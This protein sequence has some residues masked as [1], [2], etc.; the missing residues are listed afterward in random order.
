MKPPSV[1]KVKIWIDMDNSPHVPFFIPIIKELERRGH[2]VVLTTRDE[3]Q[4]CRLADFHKLSYRKIGKHYGANKLLKLLGTLWRSLQLAPMILKERPDLSLSHGSRALIVLSSVLRIPTIQAFDYE[5]AQQ[6]P[7]IVPALGVAPRA[8]D[9][10]SLAKR[11][12][13]GLRTYDGLKED[14]YVSSFKPDPSILKVLG[15][16]TDDIVA[17]IRPPATQAHY[18]NP[19]AE[20]LFVQ[21]VEMLGRTPGVRMVIVPRY[22]KVQRDLVSETWPEWCKDGR[23]IV[24]RNAL[25]GLNLIWHSDLVISGG[26]T[27]NRE[28][29]ALGVPV[30]SIFRG[31]LGAVDRYLA[32]EGRLTLLTTVEDVTSKLQPIKRT[33]AATP[34]FGN[35]AALNQILAAIEEIVAQTRTRLV[36][37]APS[38]NQRDYQ[39]DHAANPRP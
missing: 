7:F 19:E 30:Y 9:T 13:Y 8:I 24:P 4:V 31:P 38:A 10:P 18:H 2:R 6:L 37:S 3:S 15:L 29:A 26:G 22:E 23:I 11:F 36:P 35:R 5:H 39:A 33:R 17:T 25:D 14:V 28:A 27:M 32:E 1:Q 21:V 34:D 20:R 12:K 16:D